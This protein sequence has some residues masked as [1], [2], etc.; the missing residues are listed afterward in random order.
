MLINLL[1]Y[2]ANPPQAIFGMSLAKRIQKNWF[3]IKFYL[4]VKSK[5]L[6]KV[7]FFQGKGAKFSL[8]E[9]SPPLPPLATGL[10]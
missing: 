7:Y 2:F 10:C 3:A 9:A 4:L 8:G 5:I 6:K 1:L